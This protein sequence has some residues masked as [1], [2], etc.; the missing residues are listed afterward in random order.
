MI[1]TEHKNRILFFFTLT[2]RNHVLSHKTSLNKFKRKPYKVCSRAI[3]IKL[4]IKNN[5][6]AKKTSNI[7]RLNNTLLNISQRRLSK[8]IRKYFKLDDTENTTY[9]SWRGATEAVGSG[10]FI[11]ADSN[12]EE[13]S[14]INGLMSTSRS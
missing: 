8:E 13:S 4:E 2:K 6:I 14:K 11:A 12:K 10:T 1:L 9:H 3:T 5:T 7:W